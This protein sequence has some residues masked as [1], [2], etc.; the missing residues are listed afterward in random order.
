MP[1]RSIVSS[2]TSEVPP[3][4]RSITNILQAM[5]S[6]DV[7]PGVLPLSPLS[8]RSIQPLQVAR[9]GMRSKPPQSLLF[10]FWFARRC[11]LFF[12][13]R[14]RRGLSFVLL[15]QVHDRSF[16]LRIGRGGHLSL[17]RG[18]GFRARRFIHWRDCMVFNH[19]FGMD[20]GRVNAV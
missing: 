9:R 5:M 4:V 16:G 3:R 17:L 18:G 13:G 12:L 7:G 6:P 1:A 8:G 19:S 15:C 10:I 2:G 14:W 20:I 11:T